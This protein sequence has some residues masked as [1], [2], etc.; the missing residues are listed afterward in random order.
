MPQVFGRTSHSS[1]GPGSRERARDASRSHNV[2]GAAQRLTLICHVARRVE[3]STLFKVPLH[4]SLRGSHATGLTV[5]DMAIRQE[6]GS[7][8]DELAASVRG[9]ER[10]SPLYSCGEI[11]R[12]R[13]P[14]SLDA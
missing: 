7:A 5:A 14:R 12:Y 8:I 4:A 3:S 10:E 11:D 9:V 1:R 2:V 6:C 13:S